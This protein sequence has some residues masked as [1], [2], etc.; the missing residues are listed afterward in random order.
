M[1]TYIC[2]NIHKVIKK[3][4]TNNDNITINHKKLTRCNFNSCY[5]S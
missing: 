2:N 1:I 5:S 3:Q 4:N